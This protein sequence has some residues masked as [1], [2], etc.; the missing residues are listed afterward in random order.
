[1]TVYQ[2]FR[3]IWR[4]YPQHACTFSNC[5]CGRGIRRGGELCATCLVEKLTKTGQVSELVAKN[6]INL[7]CE[8][9]AIERAV[10]AVVGEDVEL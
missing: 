1:M 2:I 8:I 7:I 10:A 4:N 5:E 3:S 6:Y 9:R